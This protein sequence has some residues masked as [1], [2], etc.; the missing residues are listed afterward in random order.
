[1]IESAPRK[2]ADGERVE[3][4]EVQGSE[5]SAEQI[6]RGAQA[7]YEHQAEGHIDPLG[8]D[9]RSER[10]RESHRRTAEAVLRSALS[11]SGDS[12]DEARR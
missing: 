1:M 11:G 9:G 8:W 3:L 4:V 12:G 6:E 7:L 10:L 5:P 2:L